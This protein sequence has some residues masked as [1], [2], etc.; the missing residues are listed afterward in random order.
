MIHLPKY[1][2]GPAS[3]E[4][5]STLHPDLQALCDAVIKQVD[6]TVVCGHRTRS[7]QNKAFDS[8]VSKV[9]YPY[10]RH[11]T[12]PS[13]AVDLAPYCNKLGGIDWDNEKGFYFFGGVVKATAYA[14]LCKGLIEHEIRWGGDWDSDN[15]LTD[16]SFNDLVHFELV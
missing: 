15:D 4:R 1:R 16:Q 9:R 7:E 13:R 12:K 10:S 8:G 6:C 3:W 11:N 2:F 5:R 14:L